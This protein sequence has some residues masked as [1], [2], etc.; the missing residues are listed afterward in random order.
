RELSRTSLKRSR[1]RRHVGQAE[2]DEALDRR[3]LAPVAVEGLEDELDARVEA[4]ELVRPGADR[5]LAEAILA[6]ALDV[7]V[8][9]HPAGAGDERAV[10]GGEIGPRLLEDEAP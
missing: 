6:H 7:P 9:H 10:E 5:R 8:R 3:R 2:E 4:H 1:A